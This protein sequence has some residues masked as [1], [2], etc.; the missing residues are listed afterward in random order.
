MPVELKISSLDS[1]IERAGG[2]SFNQNQQSPERRTFWGRPESCVLDKNKHRDGSMLSDDF[3]KAQTSSRA[4]MP[5]GDGSRIGCYNWRR[6][7]DARCCLAASI[8]ETTRS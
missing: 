3:A 6:D 2:W 4:E 8:E 1:R 7:D 5:S